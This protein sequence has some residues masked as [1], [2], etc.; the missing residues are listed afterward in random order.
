MKELI[1]LRVS[2]DIEKYLSQ[3]YMRLAKCIGSISITDICIF[4]LSSNDERWEQILN[5]CEKLELER[6]KQ[7]ASHKFKE[8]ENIANALT[9]NALERG[10][11]VHPLH[12]YSWVCAK[13]SYSK[14]EIFAAKALQII[15]YAITQFTRK[16]EDTNVIYDLSSKCKMCGIAK[17]ISELIFDSVKFP[18]NKDIIAVMGYN[19][20]IVSERFAKIIEKN[21]ANDVV[22]KNIHLRKKSVICPVQDWKQLI[23]MPEVNASE[24]TI[25]G[26]DYFHPDSN[27]IERCKVCGLTRGQGIQSELYIDGNTW[28]NKDIVVTKEHIGGGT[29]IGFP[30]QM[31]VV[32]QG[33]YR[34]MMENDIKG[35]HLEIANIV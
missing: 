34:L 7:R 27:G 4:E 35:F 25:F 8:M 11:K 31:M 30:V 22:I 13:R 26:Y 20:I 1:Q 14:R 10:W 17:Q 15:P 33:F 19:E 23:V 6:Q 9:K 12:G 32:S 18:K 16:K 5:A 21:Y 28:S 24:K 3:N 2:P 29:T